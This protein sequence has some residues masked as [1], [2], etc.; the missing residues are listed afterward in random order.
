MILLE[1]WFLTVN[2]YTEAM[3]GKRFLQELN[4]KS[5]VEKISGGIGGCAYAIKTK[6]DPDKTTRLLS[7]VGINVI[8]V[9]S[10]RYK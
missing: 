9:R 1:T 3:N 8:A 6:N 7:T 5:S 4:I 2:S 10:G